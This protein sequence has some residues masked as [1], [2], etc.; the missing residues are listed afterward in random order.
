ML[1][2]VKGWKK[3]HAQMKVNIS[4]LKIIYEGLNFGD[5]ASPSFLDANTATSSL[6]EENLII[7][8]RKETPSNG[9][10]KGKFIPV[11]VSVSQLLLTS[12]LDWSC[13]RIVKKIIEL[14]P[15]DR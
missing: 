1:N 8:K 5:V 15:L 13:R 14:R 2:G 6:M 12:S 7:K 9:Y 4:E 11:F 10:E 3:S